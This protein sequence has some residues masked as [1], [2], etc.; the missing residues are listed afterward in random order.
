MLL[1]PFWS[2]VEVHGVVMLYPESG[3]AAAVL[4][5]NALYP[6]LQV[7]QLHFKIL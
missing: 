2:V 1:I 6:V 5:V 4:Y 7:Q 3:C